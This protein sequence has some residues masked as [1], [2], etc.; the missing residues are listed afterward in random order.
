M[1]HEIAMRGLAAVVRRHDAAER[2]HA[3]ERAFLSQAGVEGADLDQMSGVGAERLLVYRRLVFNRFL[4]AVEMSIPRSAIRRGRA[5][6]RADVA[7][8][9]ERKGSRSP[10]LRD[11]A[12]EF[13]SWVVPEWGEDP[14][15]PE[16]L[17]D[18]A[19]H[20]LLSFEIAS[21]KDEPV[22]VAGQELD[23]GRGALFQ[24]S[25]RVVHY[26][27]AVHELPADEDD[28]TEPARQEVSLLAYRDRDHRVRYLALGPVAAG[29][30]AELIDRESNLRESIERGCL[31]AGVET[32]DEILAGVAELLADLA[33]RGVLL[34]PAAR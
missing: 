12:S 26:E 21:V 17:P 14:G 27:F 4:S 3:D 8:F 24:R 5:A 23:L 10:Y 16:Y 6:F 1:Q 7:A 34:G 29:V 32:D 18:L 33:E 13:V 15:V 9:L 25:A 30:L 19:R 22:P 28:L 31:A 11:I 20:E 2:L